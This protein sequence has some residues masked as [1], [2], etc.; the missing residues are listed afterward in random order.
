MVDNTQANDLD[1]YMQD[2]PSVTD[3]VQIDNQLQNQ[4]D[5]L[6]RQQQSL[7]ERQKQA[8]QQNTEQAN[9]TNVYQTLYEWGRERNIFGID[10]NELK[11]Y[12]PNFNIN[13][14]E[15]FQQ[16][17]QIQAE[18]QAEEMLKQKFVGWSD[19]KIEDFIDAINNGAS[20]ADYA[21]LYKEGDWE[22]LDLRNTVN[23]KLVI[24]KDLEIQGKS[25]QYIDDYIGMLE[26]SNKLGTYAKE[27]QNSL[28]V[29]QD[30][31]KQQYFEN[32][33]AE[34]E[35]AN[36]QLELYE[37]TFV[38]KLNY[39][40]NVAGLSI[41]VNEKNDLYGFVFESKPLYYEDGTPYVDEGGNQHYS[42]DYQL[43]IQQLD[44]EE[45]MELQMLIARYMLNGKK[46]G[47]IQDM[48]NKQVSTL[49][50]KL[51]NV[52]LNQQN[53]YTPSNGAD[54]LAQHIYSDKG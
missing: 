19:K 16:L 6:I 35:L 20:I 41:D 54:A 28:V 14:E 45:Q 22:T 40:D 51:K 33:K 37:Q 23:Q 1:K 30:Q 36:R 43:M 29:S 5:E 47:G 53:K 24:R 21:E 2:Q 52:N 38:N 12:D 8:G 48:Y 44:E 7:Q 18:L 11:Q 34:N 13:S 4:Q 17:M 50:Q 32:L 9:Q 42:T 26:D 31:Q 25:K 3:E 15:G 10:L 27:H 46:L 39:T 49:E